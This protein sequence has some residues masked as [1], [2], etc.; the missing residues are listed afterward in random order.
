M[1]NKRPKKGTVVIIGRNKNY[2]AVN[3]KAK[4]RESK[5]FIADFIA[6]QTKNATQR[7]EEESFDKDL[8]QSTSE[9]D[10]EVVAVEE[11]IM[12]LK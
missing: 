5:N 12:I 2:E 9:D 6:R 7:V 1:P 8:T 11:G 10:S 4:T 3:K